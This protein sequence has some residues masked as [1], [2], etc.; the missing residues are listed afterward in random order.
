MTGA[1]VVGHAP[2]RSTTYSRH[3]AHPERRRPGRHG[4][5]PTPRPGPAGG[6]G[7]REERCNQRAADPASDRMPWIRS[8]SPPSA[9]GSCADTA[10]V[11]SRAAKSPAGIRTG[12]HSRASKRA[13]SS[14][15][16]PAARSSTIASAQLADQ[17]RRID[18]V[19]PGASS[20]PAGTGLGTGGGLRICRTLGPRPDQSSPCYA[21]SDSTSRFR[22]SRCS[23]SGVPARPN[24][25][26]PN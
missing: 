15:P 6:A 19:E 2:H 23:C 17:P 8:Q 3:P 20:G 14:S 21:V 4:R 10:G 26:S 25:S 24:W 7:G 9:G 13:R 5:P 22:W 1:G 11:F 16:A 18:T 12:R